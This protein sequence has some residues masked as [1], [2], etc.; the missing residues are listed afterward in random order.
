LAS[1]LA[2][3]VAYD[4]QLRDQLVGKWIGDIYGH[5][6]GLLINFDSSGQVYMSP[7]V[8]RPRPDVAGG[9]YSFNTAD[10]TGE[11]TV[12]VDTGGRDMEKRTHYVRLTDDDTL[13]L[14]E[15]GPGPT[16][17]LTRDKVDG[18]VN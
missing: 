13:I 7:N 11:L 3:R 16:L 5:K 14:D 6:N 8:P 1:A 2:W 4:K 10:R 12:W 17:R 15:H 9:R 18:S